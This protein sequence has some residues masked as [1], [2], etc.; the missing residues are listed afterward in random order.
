MSILID[1]L[2]RET[3]VNGLNQLSNGYWY[4][5]KPCGFYGWKGLIER[6]K[7]AWRVL[8]GKSRAYHYAEDEENK[9]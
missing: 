3:G 8:T 1:E 6:V 5:A 9:E 4:I 7:D 2:V